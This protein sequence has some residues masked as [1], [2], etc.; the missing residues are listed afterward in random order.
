[1]LVAY[2]MGVLAIVVS[3]LLV[4]GE[5][6]AQLFFGDDDRRPLA[7]GGALLIL[8]LFLTAGATQTPWLQRW[9]LRPPPLLLLVPF[10]VVLATVLGLSSFGWRLAHGLPLWILVGFQAFRLPLELLMSAAADAGLMPVQM[11]FHGY[12]FDVVSGLT[13]LPLAILL[14]DGEP[15]RR[16]VC[17][18]N[19]V[20]LGLFLNV[21]VIAIA[22]L[23]PFHAFGTGPQQLNTWITHFP[24]IWLPCVLVPAALLGHLVLMRRLLER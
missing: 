23:P 2:G 5:A 17:L 12:N 13:A 15:H 22:S 24:Y 7:T 1:M 8:W 6:R 3:S 4:V 9:D 11:S 10:G 18:W 19:I 21:V 20:G 14:L 16:L